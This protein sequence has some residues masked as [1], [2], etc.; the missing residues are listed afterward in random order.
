MIEDV[1]EPLARYR[2]EFRE[3]FATLAREKFEELTERSG[4]DVEANRALVAEI[5]KL[6][7]AAGSARTKKT[8]YGCLMSTG[9][10]GAVA[11]LIYAMAANGAEKQ[12]LLWAILGMVPGLA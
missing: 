8:C 12:P 11:A 7:R 2:D 9:F 4:V 5:K 1:Y 3:K 10:I 6:Q